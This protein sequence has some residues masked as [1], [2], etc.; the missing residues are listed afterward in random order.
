ME[1]KLLS[2][3]IKKKKKK[4]YSIYILINLNVTYF[5]IHIS[6]FNYSITTIY[7]FI[8]G[9]HIFNQYAG[10]LLLVTWNKFLFLQ[11]VFS[12]RPVN[13]IFD[14]Y[15]FIKMK[16]KSSLSKKKKIQLANFSIQI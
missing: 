15:I 9:L 5:E 8:I 10:S 14:I 6:K 16:I 2:T 11:S 7:S 4:M 3:F 13:K 12:L 1:L